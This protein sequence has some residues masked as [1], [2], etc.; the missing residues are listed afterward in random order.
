MGDSLGVKQNQEP[1]LGPGSGLGDGGEG[2]TARTRQAVA[3]G[4]WDGQSQ[5]SI[6]REAGSRKQEEHEKGVRWGEKVM[7]VNWSGRWVGV[8]SAVGEA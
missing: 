3:E 2:V 8:A 5:A 6:L 7:C 4:F 1:Q